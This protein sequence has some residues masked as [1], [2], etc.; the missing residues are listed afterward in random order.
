MTEKT[1]IQFEIACGKTEKTVEQYS[2][3]CEKVG[4]YVLGCG[5]EE[6]GP[7]E[8]EETVPIPDSD[9]IPETDVQPVP[10][11]PVKQ[12]V[13]VPVQTEEADKMAET[14]QEKAEKE[15]IVG[16][17]EEFESEIQWP[18]D[19]FEETEE[20]EEIKVETEYL[21]PV[22]TEK[23]EQEIQI[24]YPERVEVQKDITETEGQ[25]PEIPAP[26]LPMVIVLVIMATIFMLF[27][28]SVTIYCYDEYK[29]YCPLGRLF[30]RRHAVGYQV[31]ISD[32]K[33][34]EGTTGRY[35]IAL[36]GFMLK[37]AATK[38]LVVEM[39]GQKLK[40]ALEEYVDFTL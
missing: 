34:V 28:N 19:E 10:D 31:K 30:V 14:E 38:L 20:K 36:K 8:M 12:P 25:K 1:I 17:E 35:R 33:L 37:A 6:K 21:E 5:L 9:T 3:S 13:K 26:L 4:E 2:L 22:Y 32:K 24:I 16:P 27:R 40:F 15:E 23:E 7:E 39:K 29:R 11:T 18:E